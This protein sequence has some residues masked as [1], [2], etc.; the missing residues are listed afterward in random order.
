MCI[1]D[2]MGLRLYEGIESFKLFDKSIIESNAFR[3]LQNKKILNVKSGM[4]KVEENY[5]IKLDSIIDFL[6]NS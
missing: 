4:L 5:M 2:R 6:I 3:E 1:R